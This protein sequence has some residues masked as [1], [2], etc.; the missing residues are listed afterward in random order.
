MEYS[1]YLHPILLAM[2]Q[3]DILELAKLGNLK[4][5]A[6]LINLQTQP[7][8]IKAKVHLTNGCLQI[9]LESAQV[10]DQQTLVAFLRKGITSLESDWIEKVRIYGKQTSDEFPAWSQEFELIAPTNSA[11]STVSLK[12]HV[13]SSNLQRNLDSFH[14]NYNS[15]QTG[16][17]II[18]FVSCLIILQ[19]PY[20]LIMLFLSLLLLSFMRQS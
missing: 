18:C 8:G 7:K 3:P 11:P 16:I 14:L 20:A 2:S 5:L 4:A 6:S 10:P 1:S 9:M 17:V 19:S 15:K 12:F 13:F